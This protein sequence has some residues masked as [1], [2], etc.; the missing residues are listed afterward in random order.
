M[1]PRG[2]NVANPAAAIP[3]KIEP[4]TVRWRVVLPGRGHSTPIA[5]GNQ[6]FLTTADEEAGTQS[7]VAIAKSGK[8]AW[9]KKIHEGGITSENHP[10]NTA[11]TPTI[12]SDGHALF[13]VFHNSDAIQLT[14]LSLDG[15]RLW[16][17]NVGRFEPVEFKFG[18]APSPLLYKDWII[19]VADYDG[20]AWM[21]AMHRENGNEVWRIDRPG[22]ISFSSPIVGRVAGKDQL[23]LSGNNRIAS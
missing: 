3:V 14:S 6:L 16:Q 5:I 9:E 23:L 17:K 15:K 10:K 18:Y 12:A 2:N 7:V 19:V 20:P 13:V 8:I 1:V 11:A 4:A 21:T 22:K